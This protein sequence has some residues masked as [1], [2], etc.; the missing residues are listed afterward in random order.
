MT[1]VELAV[2]IG[3]EP[4]ALNHLLANKSV[5]LPWGVEVQ[6]KTLLP[7][8]KTL[9][10]GRL[11]DIALAYPELSDN[12]LR[13]EVGRLHGK[14]LSRQSITQY[15]KNSPS[16]PARIAVWC[17]TTSNSGIFGLSRIQHVP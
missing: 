15:R 10:L 1:Q 6:I 3:T 14:S 2:R 16:V 9:I 8:S 17:P 11:E 12:G 4:S 13:L 5:Q 7:N